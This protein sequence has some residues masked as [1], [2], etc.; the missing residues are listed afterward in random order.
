M[1]SF[2]RRSRLARRRSGALPPS[3]DS[4]RKSRFLRLPVH[5][6]SRRHAQ[7][8]Q[9]GHINLR[10]SHS[11]G[12]RFRPRVRMTSWPRCHVTK[13]CLKAAAPRACAFL[14]SWMASDCTAACGC[15]GCKQVHLRHEW[16]HWK[17]F[18]VCL[19]AY[20]SGCSSMQWQKW[21]GLL[22]PLP[23]CVPVYRNR[24]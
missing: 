10:M 22:K 24:I 3:K 2:R 5:A 13:I 16:Y 4:C 19:V 6:R 20:H 7:S 21:H 11:Y 9:R 17:L 18:Q 23:S 1:H 8:T 15:A 14:H 12:T